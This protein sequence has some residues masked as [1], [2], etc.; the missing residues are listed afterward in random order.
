MTT[1]D[2]TNACT[3]DQ[4]CACPPSENIC[5]CGPTCDC[6]ESC[7]CPPSA[8]TAVACGCAN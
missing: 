3:C 4:T 5:A 2:Q 1:I 6:G 8:S 7:T